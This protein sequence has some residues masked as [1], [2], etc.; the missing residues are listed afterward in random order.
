MRTN[1]IYLN[2]AGLVQVMDPLAK[3]YPTNYQYMFEDEFAEAYL[4]P[5]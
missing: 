4:S 5:N 2:D 1:N 3:G